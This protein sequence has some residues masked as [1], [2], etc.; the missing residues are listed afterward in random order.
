[1][2]P[3]EVALAIISEIVAERHG[4]AGGSLSAWRRETSHK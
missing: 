4:A 3:E 2:S 1:V